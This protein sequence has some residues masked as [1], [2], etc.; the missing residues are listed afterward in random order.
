MPY[1][2]LADV[3]LHYRFDGPVGAPALVL[4]N[5]L[6]ADLAMWD[7]QMPRLTRD[8]R[9]LRYDTRGHGVSAVTPGPYTVE[10]LGN[11]VVALLD[12][13]ALDRV[14][15]CGLSLGGMTGMWLGV[16]A[17]ARIARLVLA[18]TAARIAPPICGMRGSTRSVQG[19]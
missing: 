8:H 11:D 14:M 1:A 7:A 5:S 6:G 4:S 13:L 12:H 18:N 10:H 3:R 9:V 2:D 15:F 16:H 17:P 19:A